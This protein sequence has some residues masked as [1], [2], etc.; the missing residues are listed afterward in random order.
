MRRRGAPNEVGNGVALLDSLAE[1]RSHAFLRRDE[2]WQREHQTQQIP[3][4]AF[5][6]RHIVGP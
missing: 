6:H 1:R 2:D 4:H 5:M 3:H